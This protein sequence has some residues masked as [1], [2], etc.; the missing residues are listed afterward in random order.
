[1]LVIGTGEQVR[2]RLLDTARDAGLEGIWIFMMPSAIER[3]PRR[4][5]A[6]LGKVLGTEL[7]PA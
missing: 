7:E 6:R 5:L 3:D 2:E 4:I 1:M